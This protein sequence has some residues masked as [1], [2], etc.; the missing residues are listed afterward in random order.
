MPA[1]KFV[2]FL[3]L[4]DNGSIACV[5]TLDQLRVK[6]THRSYILWR[7]IFVGGDGILVDVLDG[8]DPSRHDPLYELY[9][10]TEVGSK[11]PTYSNCPA[12]SD[13][14][15]MKSPAL[16]P[17]GILTLSTNSM[18]EH[19]WSIVKLTPFWRIQSSKSRNLPSPRT[20]IVWC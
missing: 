8:I 10:I 13:E 14:N 3:P 4:F 6:L 7:W 16:K 2:Q 12:K 20:R 11:L 1:Q 5:T 18:S 9:I 19:A 15:G 17:F